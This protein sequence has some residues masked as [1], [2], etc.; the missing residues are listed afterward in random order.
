MSDQLKQAAETFFNKVKEIDPAIGGYVDE[1][2]IIRG[3][4]RGKASNNYQYSFMAQRFLVN[5][6]GRSVS[7]PF[8]KV[9]AEIK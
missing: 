7:D 1:N 5:N 9:L 6:A 2:L 8:E 3:S 4:Y